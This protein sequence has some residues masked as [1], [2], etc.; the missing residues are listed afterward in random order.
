MCKTSKMALTV[1]SD[2]ISR[3]TTTT[4]PPLDSAVVMVLEANC[5][6]P[7]PSSFGWI[8]TR[9]VAP[10]AASL[11]EPTAA[12]INQKKLVRTTG[13]TSVRYITFIFT[14]LLAERK[15]A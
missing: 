6:T 11:G 12:Y 13:K 2:P 8:S 14:Y 5:S 7:N 9:A 1:P 4:G 3:C 10:V 15:L